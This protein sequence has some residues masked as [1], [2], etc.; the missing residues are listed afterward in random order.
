MVMGITIIHIR[1][2]VNKGLLGKRIPNRPNQRI[3][4]S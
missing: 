1:A 4:D 3:T 2:K